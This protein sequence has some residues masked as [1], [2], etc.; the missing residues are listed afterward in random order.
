MVTNRPVTIIASVR[1]PEYGGKE[2]VFWALCID[3]DGR[4]ASCS[5]IQ[6]NAT[7]MKVPV[8]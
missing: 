7:I 5:R 4:S 1:S 8:N 3:N 2:I 6:G